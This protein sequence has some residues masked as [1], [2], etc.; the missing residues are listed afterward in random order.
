MSNPTEESRST[1]KEPLKYP[2]AE[3]DKF[4]LAKMKLV[5]EMEDPRET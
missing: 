5:V 1:E 3:D 4:E 2:D